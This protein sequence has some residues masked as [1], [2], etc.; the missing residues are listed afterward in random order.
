M[1]SLLWSG[2]SRQC[3][4]CKIVR[5]AFKEA[6]YNLSIDFYEWKIAKKLAKTSKFDGLL[7]AYYKKEK[8]GKQIIIWIISFLLDLHEE[9]FLYFFPLD[10]KHFFI[11]IICEDN[12]R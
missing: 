3:F 9:C 6:N 12:Y 8:I 1:A 4:F 10:K 2:S 5:S 11:T 7:G